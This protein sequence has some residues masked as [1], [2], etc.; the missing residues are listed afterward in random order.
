M[1]NLQAAAVNVLQVFENEIT[2]ESYLQGNK[3]MEIHN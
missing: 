2:A 1:V 3:C